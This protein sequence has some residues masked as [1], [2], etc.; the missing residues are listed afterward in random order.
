MGERF[1]PLTLAVGGLVILALQTEVTLERDKAGRWRFRM[2]KQPMK[3]STLGSL[4][5]KLV[6]AATGATQ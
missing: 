5:G 6:A 1:D 2:R 4:L 3:D